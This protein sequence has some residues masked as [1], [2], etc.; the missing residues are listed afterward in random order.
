M[1]MLLHH[2]PRAR[3]EDF[4]V[5]EAAHV[6]AAWELDSTVA[7]VTFDHTTWSGRTHFATTMSD[8][9]DT[10]DYTRELAERH[11]IILHAG[12]AAQLVFNYEAALRCTP[13]SDLDSVLVILMAFERDPAV[14]L[15]WSTYL[16]E[17]ALALVRR[18]ETWRRIEE[19]TRFLGRRSHISRRQ[20][21][22][23]RQRVFTPDVTE[24]ASA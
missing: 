5:H 15:A 14:V 16:A 19:V 3:K 23:L 8:E 13:R 4:L 20:L 7:R 24:V 11:V 1:T 17:R 21:T 6:V 12:M 18:P 10:S 9:S 2:P 22:A